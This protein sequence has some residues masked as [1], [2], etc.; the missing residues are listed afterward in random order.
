MTP[1][2]R[3]EVPL[4]IRTIGRP[5]RGLRPS[6]AGFVHPVDRDDLV[7]HGVPQHIEPLAAADAVAPAL[8]G[9]F[10]LRVRPEM[11]VLRPL[12][13]AASGLRACDVALAAEAELRLVADPAP[14]TLD[15]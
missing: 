12:L 11:K 5:A 8:S 13:V 9:M 3:V 7:G 6:G 15:P 4:F 10:A 14:G 1:A 2:F